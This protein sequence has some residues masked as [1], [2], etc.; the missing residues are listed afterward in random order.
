[1]WTRILCTFP[2]GDSKRKKGGN[3]RR[4]CI[5]FS[6]TWWPQLNFDPSSVSMNLY[7]LGSELVKCNTHHKLKVPGGGTRSPSRL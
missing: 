2:Q 3:Q 6:N 4:F 1:M 7:F 5:V